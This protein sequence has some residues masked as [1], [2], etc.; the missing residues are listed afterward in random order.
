MASEYAPGEHPNSRRNL[1]TTPGPGRP[2]K[3]K[4]EEKI[5]DKGVKKHIELYLKEGT[6]AEDFE[7]VRQTNPRW[8]LEF[9]SDRVWGKPIATNPGGDSKP[10]ASS[11]AILVQVLCGGRELPPKELPQEAK[12]QGI[13]D[14]KYPESHIHTPPALPE[15][16]K[17]NI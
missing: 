3:R 13:E 17:E 12:S 9:A 8:C 16:E 10:H 2:K 1:K 7:R 6:G 4:V 14:S 11:V 5:L 15:T